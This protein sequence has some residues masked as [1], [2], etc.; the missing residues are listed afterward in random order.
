MILY[1]EVVVLTPSTA[2]PVTTP[3]P[4]TT[5]TIVSAVAPVLIRYLVVTV[6]TH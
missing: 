4:V 6:V 2:E 5:V 1:L 3:F